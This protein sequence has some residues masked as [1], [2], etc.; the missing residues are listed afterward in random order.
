MKSKNMNPMIYEKTKDGEAI[1]DVYSRLV[2]ERILFLAEEIEAELAT[3]LTAT[4]FWLD[5]QSSTQEITL[6]INSPGGT[7][8]DGLLTIYDT[9][10][11]IKAPVRTICIGEAYSG[12]AVILAAGTKGRRLAYPNAKIMIHP[13][14]VG[15]LSGSQPEIEK[16]AKRIKKLNS[17]LI[18][19][20]AR[21]SGQ[22]L[23]KVRKDCQTDKFMSADEALEY[24]L[25]DE[26]VKPSKKVPELYE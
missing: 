6:Y 4:L 10:Q 17:S 11:V 20:I 9:L 2:K 5:S 15:E 21:H 23:K 18:E 13:I 14:Q 22:S 3:T 12:A 7:V 25:I 8:S 24:G 16:E 26:I 19:L 1:Y